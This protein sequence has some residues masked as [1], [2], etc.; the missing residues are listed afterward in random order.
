MLLTTFFFA[1]IVIQFHIHWQHSKYYQQWYFFHQLQ[2]Q[3]KQSMNNAKQNW[4]HY[5]LLDWKKW[6]QQ[7]KTIKS[8]STIAKQFYRHKQ[9]THSFHYLQTILPQLTY[10]HRRSNKANFYIRKKYL[11]F[12]MFIWLQKHQQIQKIQSYLSVSTKK[13]SIHYLT[14]KR[15]F[16]S[17]QQL[18]CLFRKIEN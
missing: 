15:V 18:P 2:L 13:F 3:K 12:A 5:Y 16:Q 9:L 8:V 10:Y 7:R 6:Y 1:I 11:S 4:I 17:F 14:L